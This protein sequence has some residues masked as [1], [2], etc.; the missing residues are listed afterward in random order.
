M[1]S[2]S[3]SK[4]HTFQKRSSCFLII[5]LLFFPFLA[6]TSAEDDLLALLN[7]EVNLDE[8]SVSGKRSVSN[9]KRKLD[10]AQYE[11]FKLFNKLVDDEEF[12]IICRRVGKTGTF[13]RERQCRPGFIKQTGRIGQS[14]STSANYTD[15]RSA[16]FRAYRPMDLLG[17]M[18]SL[19]R[20]SQDQRNFNRLYELMIEL[21]SKDENL[22][23]A[24]IRAHHLRLL[25]QELVKQEYFANKE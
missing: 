15:M 3:I 11:Q 9:V 19:A 24:I 13:L 17:T 8:I 23:N 10:R 16:N 7:Q 25:H 22:G 4:H 14:D 20:D 2:I 1:G 21:G 18:S 12:L 5:L 6:A